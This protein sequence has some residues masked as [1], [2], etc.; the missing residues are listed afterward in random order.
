MCDDISSDLRGVCYRTFAERTLDPT[1]CSNIKNEAVHEAVLTMCYTNIAIG[2]DDLTVC[3]LDPEP[4]FCYE[5]AGRRCACL[6]WIAEEHPQF[7][8][9]VESKGY[10]PENC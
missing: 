2:K 3:E 4:I 1:L 6:V 5:S 9:E 7:C 8:R 10:Y